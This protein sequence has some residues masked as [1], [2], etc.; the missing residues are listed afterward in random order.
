MKDTIKI[1]QVARGDLQAD[2]VLKNCKILDVFGE[3][4]IEG[5]IAIVD[6]WIVGIGSYSGREERDIEGQYVIPGLIDGHVHIESSLLTPAQF[7]M[8]VVP[9]GTTTVIADPHEIAN[10]CGAAGIR[11][12]L[13]SSEV[14]PIDVRIM[15]PSCV[16]STDFEQAGA[17]L[18]A[19]DLEDLMNLD[20]VLGLGEMMNYPGVVLGNLAVH[21]KLKLFDGQIIDGHSPNL[22]G[23]ALN[24]YVAAGVITDHECTT[25]QEMEERL[26]LGMHVLIREG[27]A[28][29]NLSTLIKGV[30]DANDNRIAFCTD[31]KQPRDIM[32]DGHINYNVNRA[33]ELGIKPIKAIK[34]ATINTA[35]CYRLYDRGAIAP[36]YLA[37]LIVTK[38]LGLIE[39]V[40]VYKKGRLVAKNQECLATVHQVIDQSLENSV[41]IKDSSNLNLDLYLTSDI[42]RVI[43]L[44]K[45]NITTTEVPRKVDLENHLFKYN[46]K[47]DILKIAV[48]ERHHQTGNK[49]IGLLEGYGLKRGAIALTIAHDSHN[50]IVIG[51]NDE[52]MKTAV[53]T[54]EDM[55]GGMVIIDQGNVIDTLRLEVAG[56]MTNQNADQVEE[57]LNRLS[58]IAYEMGVDPD[59]EPF[60]TLAFM[61]LPVI[62]ELKLTDQGLFD[63]KAFEFVEVSYK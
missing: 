61:A 41:N 62:P 11:Y 26:R 29:K 18:K 31:D 19:V 34:M 2:F 55:G 5:D 20:R 42:V 6:D 30:T 50:V 39:P 54:L 40:E 28:T 43:Q 60:M 7:S 22:S 15:L 14:L 35:I 44:V 33:I 13:E 53:K 16:P 8:L 63:V 51:T 1:V 49:G 47:L 21:D 3:Q 25:V 27:S 36:G 24:A 46:P 37:D 59:V 58:E 17:I 4:I 52:D 32:A 56:L 38:E 23:K 9:K 12:M 10:V 48:I 45:H 57:A